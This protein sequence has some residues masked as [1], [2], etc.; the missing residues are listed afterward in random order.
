MRQKRGEREG[1]RSC[2]V[3]RETDDEVRV[4]DKIWFSGK[5]FNELCRRCVNSSKGGDG[6]WRTDRIPVPMVQQRTPSVHEAGPEWS[7]TRH[8][9]KRKQNGG[10]GG[11]DERGVS[12]ER[13][14]VLLLDMYPRGEAPCR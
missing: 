10:E 3:V 8:E 12:R 14:V 11:D 4:D 6:V 9:R 2:A 7:I 13:R 5:D 1:T